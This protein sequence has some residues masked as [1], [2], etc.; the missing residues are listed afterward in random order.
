MPSSPEHR[1]AALVLAAGGSR[2]LGR[3]KQLLPYG[4]GLLLDAVLGTAR[5]AGFDQIVLALGGAGDAVRRS[6]DTSGCDV[7]DNPAYADGCSSSIAAAMPALHPQTE[8]LVLLLLLA[9]RASVVSVTAC[10]PGRRAT[11]SSIFANSS[12]R[13]RP[14]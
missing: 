9:T 8:A 4:C 13:A 10:T 12:V 7:V 1:I 3:P 2:R 5:E 6:V 11:P 14:L